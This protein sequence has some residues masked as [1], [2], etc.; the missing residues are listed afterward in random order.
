M[1]KPLHFAADGSPVFA[2]SRSSASDGRG[3]AKKPR[4]EPE[5]RFHRQIAEYLT[6]ALPDGVEW[7]YTLNGVFLGHSQR[8]KATAAGLR[9]GLGDYVLLLPTRT[10]WTV[11]MIEAKSKSGSLTA[12]QRRW[13]DKLGA[14]WA[15]VETL[16]QVELA[17]RSWRIEPRCEIGKANRY[18]MAT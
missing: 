13:R 12:E 18:G 1:P 6:F 9:R 17:L 3:R 16:E 11:C 4:D 14:K 5:H 2:F 8:Q 15:T 10:G 7:T